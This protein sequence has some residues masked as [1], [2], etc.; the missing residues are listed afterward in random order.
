LLDPNSMTRALGLFFVAMALIGIGYVF[1]VGRDPILMLAQN[2]KLT[3]PLQQRKPPVLNSDDSAT[4]S[5]AR[6]SSS[7]T[8]QKA[9]RILTEQLAAEKQRLQDLQASLDQMTQTPYQPPTGSVQ[10]HV[11]NVNQEIARLQ[12]DLIALNSDQQSIDQTSLNYQRSMIAQLK[13]Q[14]LATQNSITDI[15]RQIDALQSSGQSS[16]DE[17]AR[18]NSRREL[19]R[20]E[21]NTE[22][23][24]QEQLTSQLELQATSAFEQAQAE[25]VEIQRR[26]ND[27][28]ADVS[29]WQAQ[30]ATG[31]ENSTITDSRV[32]D[33]KKQ[34]QEQQ[35]RVDNLQNQIQQLGK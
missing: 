3:P 11:D 20:S 28:R 33:L 29:Y 4:G 14:Q 6:E 24:Q 27:L 8:E 35:A 7:S 15:S 9:Q 1:G 26:L 21:L 12:Q 5:S 13:N 25:K 31:G 2:Q 32:E 17:I 30:T 18:L 16:P 22:R 19:L 10:A 23:A 34:I